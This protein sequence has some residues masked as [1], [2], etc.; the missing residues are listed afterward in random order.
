[1]PPAAAATALSLTAEEFG[2]LE[3]LEAEEG[4]RPSQCFCATLCK[5]HRNE[6]ACLVGAHKHVVLIVAVFW[7]MAPLLLLLL[8]LLSEEEKAR[9]PRTGGPA[10][11]FAELADSCDSLLSVLEINTPFSN[12]DACIDFVLH[13][14]VYNPEHTV[15]SECVSRL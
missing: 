3:E 5:R 13:A 2:R 11:E 4:D 9:L 14:F 12:L 10:V 8:L 7:V 1:M 6:P 15:A